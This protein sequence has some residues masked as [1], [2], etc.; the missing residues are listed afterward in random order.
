M[1]T[2]ARTAP[3]LAALAA[4]SGLAGCRYSSQAYHFDKAKVWS[5]AAGQAVAWHPD[6]ID[7]DDLSVE[8]V[9]T[10]LSGNEIRYRLEVATDLNPFVRRPSTRIFVRMERVKP[11]RQR[12]SQLEQDFLAK[13]QA[14]LD[15]LNPPP[16]P[17]P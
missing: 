12:F 6:S 14:K 16:Q 2:H 5:A 9:K 15:A 13:V 4:L 11:S 1:K 10:D 17:A 7:E 3:L 8:S